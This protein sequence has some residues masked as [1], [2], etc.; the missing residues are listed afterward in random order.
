M[1]L[2]QQALCVLY[3]AE[4]GGWVRVCEMSGK[5][6]MG[7]FLGS[8]A[9]KR[10]Y[11]VMEEVSS[12]GYFEALGVRYVVE[13]GKEGKFKTYRIASS[14]PKPKPVF[15]VRHPLTGERITSEQLAMI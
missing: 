9:D 13:A 4:R 3:L 2:T 1:K 10:M 12:N 14:A 7:Q 5:P 15:Y 11:E 6:F 8:Q